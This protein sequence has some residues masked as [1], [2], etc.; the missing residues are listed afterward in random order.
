MEIKA[1]WVSLG[2]LMDCLRGKKKVENV[3]F[4]SPLA[5]HNT[6]WPPT[7]FWIKKDFRFLL[8]SQMAGTHTRQ[9]LLGGCHFN[10]YAHTHTSR[11]SLG[12]TSIK[13]YQRRSKGNSRQGR[14][15]AFGPNGG[16]G[17]SALGFDRSRHTHLQGGTDGYFIRYFIEICFSLFLYLITLYKTPANIRWHSIRVAVTHER[18]P[19]E[20]Q[21][22]YFFFSLSHTWREASRDNDNILVLFTFFF[23]F[24][25]LVDRV[26]IKLYF[27]LF[28]VW[29]MWY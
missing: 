20:I 5:A 23:S 29:S 11:A 3:F 16:N 28:S 24:F 8:I 22:C 18:N 12:S 1:R 4:D 7:F 10:V 21:S 25:T 6:Q 27:F 9:Q 13:V 17:P 19:K 15:Y 14:H 2:D 26:R